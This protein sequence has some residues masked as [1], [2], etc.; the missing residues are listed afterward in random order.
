MPTHPSPLITNLT[1]LGA[2]FGIDTNSLKQSSTGETVGFTTGSGTAVK[3]DSTFTGNIGSTA[4]RLSDVV[5]ALKTLGIL[6]P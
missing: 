3:D 6:A 2:A 4:Y 5:K 1:E